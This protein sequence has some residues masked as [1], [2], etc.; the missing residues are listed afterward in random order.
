MRDDELKKLLN[1]LSDATGE[2]VRPDLVEE[3]KQQI[4]HGLSGHKGGL[5]TINI[6]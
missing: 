4:P 2:P 1:G 6:M 3:I 5:D